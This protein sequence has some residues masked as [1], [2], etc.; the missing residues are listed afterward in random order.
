M[1]I[2]DFYIFILFLTA[3]LCL[4]LFLLSNFYKYNTNFLNYCFTKIIMKIFNKNIIK[5]L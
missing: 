1:I 2:S 3:K 4:I 5:I